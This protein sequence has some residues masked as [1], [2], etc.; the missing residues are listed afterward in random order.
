[1]T[2]M[3]VLVD[4]RWT[5]WHRQY[6]DPQSFPSQR[7]PVIVGM[8]RSLLDVAAP[9]PVRCLSLCAGEARHILR[10]A[11][12]HPRRGDLAGAVVELDPGL[13]ATARSNLDRAGVPLDVR[14]GDAGRP[15]AFANLLPVDVLLL[16]G[17]FGN[18]DDDD[19]HR[20]ISA[21]PAMCRMG[22][23][24]IWTRHRRPPDRTGSVSRWFEEVGA[25]SEEFVSGG[26]GSFAVGRNRTTRSALVSELPD[27]LFTFTQ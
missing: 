4:G 24:V 16:V 11:A 22:G 6:D 27:K 5:D 21:V 14:V 9:G 1:M 19:I 2:D 25:V 3:F 7:L 17:I 12:D 8:I 13:A 18:I 23:A 26:P 10:A 20:T 15:A